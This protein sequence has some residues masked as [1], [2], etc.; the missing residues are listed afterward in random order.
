METTTDIDERASLERGMVWTAIAV[1]AGTFAVQM[2]A[3]MINVALDS[4]RQAFDVSIGSIQ[5]LSTAY[6]MAMAVAIPTVGWG[7]DRFGSRRLWL[8]A[9]VVFGAAS[10]VSGLAGSIGFLIACRVVQGLAGGILLPLSQAILA[11]AAG[12][13]R[14]GRLMAIVGVPSLLGPI[15]GPV[16]GGVLV[17][18]VGWAWIFYLN[19]PI[20]LAAVALS[21]RTMPPTAPVRAGSRAR[22]DLLGFVLLGPGLAAALYAL[23]TAGAAGSFTEAGVLVPFLAG[24]LLLTGFVIHALTTR[25][26]ALIDLRLFAS[27]TF[28]ASAGM[29][30]FIIMGLLASML[31]I[32]LYFQLARG[33][34][35]LTAGLLLAPQGLGA[36]IAIAA[37]GPLV[38]RSDPIPLTFAGILS[39]VAGLGILSRLTDSTEGWTIAAAQFLLG[40]GFGIIVVVATAVAYRGLASAAIPRA[41]TALRIVQQ[42]G[43]AIGVAA[44]AAVLQRGLTQPAAA[45]MHP[46]EVAAAFSGALTWALVATGLAIIPTAALVAALRRQAR[47]HNRHSEP[48]AATPPQPQPPSRLSVTEPASRPERGR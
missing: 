10:A 23:A 26:E 14:L 46:V 48:C 15:L 43:G 3:T 2:D 22:F 11:Q 45:L 38:D 35:A 12:P 21:L 8:G 24:V 20:C 4:L 34:S 5:L 33:D 44:V 25:H 1:V 47:P 9:L 27:R 40:V 19:V 41:T 32:P 6:L 7:V 13:E 31:L 16:I 18:D 28:T 37:S 42:I 29:L 30:F 17:R 36:A 39:A